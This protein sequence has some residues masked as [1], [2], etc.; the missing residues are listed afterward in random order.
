MIPIAL[1][2][3]VAAAIASPHLVRLDRAAPGTAILVWLAA[4]LLRAVLVAFAATFVFAVA[5]KTELFHAVTH[6]CWHTVVPLITAHL[7]V[8]GHL[9]AD[10]AIVL[11]VLIVLGSLASVLVGLYRATRRVHALLTAGIGAGPAGSVIVSDSSIVL[12]AAGMRKPRVIVSAGALTQLDDAELGAGLAHERGHIARRHRW[13]LVVA[14]VARALGR[15]IPGA[16]AALAEL[17]FHVE[18]DADRFALRAQHEPSALASA[19]CKAAAGRPRPL[20][21]FALGGGGAA[22]RVRHLLAEDPGPARSSLPRALAGA[23]VVLTLLLG[24]AAGPVTVE[25]AKASGVSTTA[26]DCPA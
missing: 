14:Q 7:G 25:A 24:I 19:I 3:V 21:A 1:L 18:R 20:S 16:R 23:L 12:A 17:A 15:P 2:A 22:R 8:S 9:L 13:I 6:F 5:P 10:I 4:L 26:E 11:P